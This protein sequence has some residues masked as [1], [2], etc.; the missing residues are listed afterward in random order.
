MKTY[1]NL[2]DLL[3]VFSHQ[4]MFSKTLLS[5]RDPASNAHIA[6]LDCSR[7]QIYVCVYI[8]IMIENLKKPG[9]CELN[10]T[11]KHPGFKLSYLFGDLLY[12]VISPYGG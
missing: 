12:P 7:P 5:Q 10:I 6:K 3:Q 2:D 9:N 8:Y 1:E 11:Y 4:V